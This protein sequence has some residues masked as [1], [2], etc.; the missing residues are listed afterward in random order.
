MGPDK[1]SGRGKIGFMDTQVTLTLP[2]YL[3]QQVEAAARHSHRPVTDLLVDVLAEAFPPVYVHPQRA[4]MLEEQQ[5]YE[6]QREAI[7]AQY[8][9]EYVA[10]HGGKVVDHDVDEIE[11]VKRIQKNYPNDVVHIRLASRKPDTELRMRSPR[12]VDLF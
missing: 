8:E 10:V 9:G 12:F 2:D 5:A 1:F 6:R 7:L 3:Y 4:R 11:L